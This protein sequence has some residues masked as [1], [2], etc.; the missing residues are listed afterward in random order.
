MNACRSCKNREAFYG[1]G[2]E[3][4]Y[5]LLT[6]VIALVGTFFFFTR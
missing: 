4:G 3:E 1:V 2:D 6:T 5:R